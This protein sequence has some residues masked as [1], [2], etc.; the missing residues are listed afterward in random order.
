MENKSVESKNKKRGVLRK[1]IISFIV[2]Q[3]LFMTFAGGYFTYYL[4]LDPAAR[5]LQWVKKTVEKRYYEEISPEALR[6]ATLDDLFYDADKLLD[7]YSAYY[8]AEAYK[9]RKNQQAGRQSGMGISFLPGSSPSEYSLVYSVVGNSPAEESGLKRGMY[10]RGYG[11]DEENITYGGYTAAFS[12]FLSAMPDG[13][14][15]VLLASESI[16]GECKPYAVYKAQYVQNYA[17]YADNEREYRYTG[18][19]ADELIVGE[20]DYGYFPE[21][22]AMIRLDSFNGGAAAQF[23]GMLN[24]FK[25]SG[26][27]RLII[28]LRN[29]GGGRMDILAEIASCLCKDAAGRKYCVANAVYRNGKK[30]VFK[31]SGNYYA[32]Y[33]TGVDVYLLVNENTAS[34]S[35]ALAGAMIDYGTLDYADVFVAETNGVAR[36]YGKGIM[37]TTY[38]N[39]LT[40]E[41]VKLTTATIRWPL[42]GE[43][44]HGKGI[45]DADGATAVHADGAA[46]LNDSM[47]REVVRILNG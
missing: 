12:S 9:T 11:A 23:K 35:E 4:T 15:F 45:T 14:S 5:T 20:S 47:L 6:S 31:A 27:T 26:N 43:C 1:V 44:I 37:Q 19:N 25:E 10:L 18:K 21:D 24:V 36:S 28:D 16:E 38:E 40:G 41:A 7:D 34:A 17:F 39:L 30:T 3:V 22:T 8:S 2:L 42:S 29:N 46:D 13:R 33:L 32:D